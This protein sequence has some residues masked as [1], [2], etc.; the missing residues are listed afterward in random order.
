M[1]KGISHKTEFLSQNKR[2]KREVTQIAHLV[3]V[4]SLTVKK[5]NH[6]KT[7]HSSSS[8]KFRTGL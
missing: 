7:Q 2:S 4:S 6:Q 5:R 8:L 3:F 1:L